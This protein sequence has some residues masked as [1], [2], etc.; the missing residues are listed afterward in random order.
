LEESIT[1]G[2]H[3]GGDEE[4]FSLVGQ[5]KKGKGKAKQNQSGGA[6]SQRKID[7]SKVKCFACHKFGHYARQCPNKKKGKGKTT[8]AAS[9][10]DG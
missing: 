5:A 10:T 8:T 7:M 3:K 1:S 6:S 4:N 2:Q 9:R